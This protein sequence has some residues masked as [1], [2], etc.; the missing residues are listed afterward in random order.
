MSLLDKTE[1]QVTFD[2]QTSFLTAKKGETWEK[3]YRF[4]FLTGKILGFLFLPPVSCEVAA[5][6]S[7]QQLQRR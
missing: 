1:A 6:S 3:K 2:L 7:D 4:L 5:G